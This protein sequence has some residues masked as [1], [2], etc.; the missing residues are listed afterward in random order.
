MA[1]LEILRGRWIT[2]RIAWTL[3]QAHTG[4][5]VDRGCLRDRFLLDGNKT[6][7]LSQ[8]VLT[9]FVTTPLGGDLR[10][11]ASCAQGRSSDSNLRG[12]WLRAEADHLFRR[13]RPH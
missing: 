11:Q 9:G 3:L 5:G 2:R 1:S 13:T 4:R 7:P 8:A 12:S 10:R 6:R